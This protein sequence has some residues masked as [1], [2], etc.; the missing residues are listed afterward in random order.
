MQNKRTISRGAF[1]AAAARVDP[2]AE[3]AAEAALDLILQELGGG[4]IAHAYRREEV[5]GDWVVDFWFPEIRLAV[6]VDGGVHRAPTRRKRDARKDSDLA[7]RGITVLRLTNAEVSGDRERLLARL[8]AAWGYAL[9]RRDGGHRVRSPG[10]ARYRRG[11]S[12]RR[13]RIAPARH[14]VADARDWALRPCV[15][16]ATPGSRPAK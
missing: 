2:P 7:A 14:R 1:G 3:T 16:G 4:A 9:A 8:R 11:E 5:V 13:C 12:A 10:L 15:G 6:E